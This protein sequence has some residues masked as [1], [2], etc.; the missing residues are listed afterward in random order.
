M[1]KEILTRENIKSDILSILLGDIVA[2]AIT[3]ILLLLLNALLKLL[4]NSI[5][6]TIRINFVLFIILTIISSLSLIHVFTLIYKTQKNQFTIKS[7][8]L[9]SK[10]EG[11]GN[12][13]TTGWSGYKPYILNFMH[14]NFYIPAKV[15]YKWSSL[16]A[17]DDK[18]IF[19]YSNPN[20]R[21]LL[22]TLN[23]KRIIMV[24]NLNL[25]DFE[26]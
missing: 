13:G 20:D 26:E 1:Q 23:G 22:V 17:M 18:S 25:F 3:Y 7:D 6:V 14:N 2:I 8:V 16:Y 10:K 15:N 11:G 4:L 9:I 5:N 24:Y 21:F 12:P 19:I